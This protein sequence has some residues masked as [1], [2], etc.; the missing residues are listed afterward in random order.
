MIGDQ[1]RGLEKQ[2]EIV[3]KRPPH[4]HTLCSCHNFAEVWLCFKKD[5]SSSV[6][7]QLSLKPGPKI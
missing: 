6:P 5:F 3:N 4:T 2:G 1:E 7:E